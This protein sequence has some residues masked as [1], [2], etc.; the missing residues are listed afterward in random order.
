MNF[1]SM[2]KTIFWI[3]RKNSNKNE[4][5]FYTSKTEKDTWYTEYCDIYEKYVEYKKTK[6]FSSDIPTSYSDEFIRLERLEK[7][8]ALKSSTRYFYIKNSKALEGQDL[9]YSF[10]LDDKYL[11]HLPTYD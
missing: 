9:L 2:V 5:T 3:T 8:I 6:T 10:Y 7:E 1:N 4:L 11:N